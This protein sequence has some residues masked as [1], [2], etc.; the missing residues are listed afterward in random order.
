M[1]R[2][3]SKKHKLGTY[4]INKIS[5]SCFDDKRYVQ[6]DNINTFAYFHKHIDSPRCKKKKDS[7]RWSSYKWSQIKISAHEKKKFSQMVIN[8][9]K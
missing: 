4:E 5:L 3:Q 2:I 6:A 8:G 1:R 9:H 7:H